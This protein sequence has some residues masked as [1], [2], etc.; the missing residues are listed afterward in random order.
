MDNA[1]LAFEGVTIKV[2][3]GYAA[4][5]ASDYAG[6]YSPN[7][8]FTKCHFVGG[9]RVGRNG[10]KFEECTFTLDASDYVYT[11]GNSVDF[12]K[13]TFNSK[14]KALIVYSDGNGIGTAPV[15]NVKNCV[16][17]ASQ[18]GYAGVISNQ[19]CAAVEIDNY[20]C[21]VNL[22]LSGNI[23]GE[24]FS[25]EW[26]IKSYYTG[27]NN[28]VTVNGTAYTTLALDGKTMTING[29]EVTVQD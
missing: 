18:K 17:N 22:T 28:A 3:L 27:K 10:A 15:V 16:F 24:N 2:G 14:G 1:K 19:E 5:G 23:V 12:S 6:I 13:C 29:T 11:Y 20:G 25:G 26:R 9:L 8:T 7:A 21:G 4:P